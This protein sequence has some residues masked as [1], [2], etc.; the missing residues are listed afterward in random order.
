VPEDEVGQ[1]RGVDASGKFR[2]G[3]V[4]ELGVRS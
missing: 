4:R 2:A 3:V 1:D